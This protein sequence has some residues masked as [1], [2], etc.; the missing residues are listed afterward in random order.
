[1]KQVATLIC[2]KETAWLEGDAK[3][4]GLRGGAEYKAGQEVGYLVLS[5]TTDL[6]PWQ[7]RGHGYDILLE[8]LIEPWKMM[9]T[10]NLV[11]VPKLLW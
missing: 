8:C 6:I 3:G 7:D 2:R 5:L 4:A 11:G 9:P 1:M 10:I